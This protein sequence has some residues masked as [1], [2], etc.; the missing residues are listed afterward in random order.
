[1]LKVSIPNFMTEYSRNSYSSVLKGSLP[2]RGHILAQHVLE[3]L[4]ISPFLAQ[5]SISEKLSEKN[6]SSKNKR[7]RESLR[8]L[9]E[10]ECI[11]K[12]KIIKYSRGHKC[13]NQNYTNDYFVKFDLINKFTD[14]IENKNKLQTKKNSSKS[15]LQKIPF[16]CNKCK[17][18]VIYKQ[19]EKY[20]I[21]LYEYWIL[22]PLGILVVLSM[23]E[24]SLSKF[25]K[26]Y[27]KDKILNVLD[28]LEKSEKKLLA[29]SFVKE[30][31]KKS[32]DLE[33]FKKISKSLIQ[34]LNSK[35]LDMKV[36][37]H[38]KKLLKLQAKINNDSI[39][40]KIFNAKSSREIKKY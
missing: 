14:Y 20:E 26:F 28:V 7:L 12:Y 40:E 32:R 15:N 33:D 3:I 37:S 27:K 31:D 13:I 18:T 29:K 9:K 17:Q 8:S 34:K 16:E 23:P 39:R 10:L 36:K 5:T 2:S 24:S 11:E 4:A 6:Q 25:D 21:Q 35:I 19:N 38:H 1:M 30:L 22:S